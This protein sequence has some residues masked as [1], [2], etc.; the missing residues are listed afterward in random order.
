MIKKYVHNNLVRYLIYL[1]FWLS[2]IASI[3]F[4]IHY[5][6]YYSIESKYHLFNLKY[7]FGYC[8]EIRHHG[9][10]TEV[11]NNFTRFHRVFF[12]KFQHIIMGVENAINY[13][14]EKYPDLLMTGDLNS[15]GSVNYKQ[16]VQNHKDDPIF[17]DLFIKYLYLSKYKEQDLQSL[18]EYSRNIDGHFYEAS[19]ETIII[20]SKYSISSPTLFYYIILNDKD[21]LCEHLFKYYL[22]K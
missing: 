6:A 2:I 12:L 15:D 1:I 17:K 4:L 22:T 14:V 3:L 7:R 8:E 5:F 10:R 11:T 9:F 16:F 13:Y 21:L 20:H 18:A 19:N